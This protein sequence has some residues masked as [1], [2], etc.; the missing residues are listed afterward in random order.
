MLERVDCLSL[1]KVLIKKTSTYLSSSDGASLALR[2][3][4]IYHHRRPAILERGI[5]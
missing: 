2:S 1:D 5:L 4:I 3:M